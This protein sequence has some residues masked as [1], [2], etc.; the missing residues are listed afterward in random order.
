[1]FAGN[2][3]A[4]DDDQAFADGFDKLAAYGNSQELG[5]QFRWIID[6]NNDG[7]VN[8]GEGD[9]LTIQPVQAGFNV[10][11]AI[12]VAGNFDGNAANGDEIGLYNLGTWVLDFDRDFIIET[13]GNDT[14]VNGNLFGFPIVGD[15]DGDG[16]DDLGVFNNDVFT[17]DLANDGLG[18]PNLGGLDFVAS[19]LPTNDQDQQFNWGFPGVLDRPVTADF[20]QDGIDD[21]GLWVPRDNPQN[22]DA[23]AEW[24]FL[25]SA[26]PTGANRVTGTVNTL[27]HAFEPSPF[28]NDLYAEFGNELASPIVGN[29]DPPVAADPDPDPNTIE[30]DPDFDQDGDVDGRD[31]LAWQ[32]GYNMASPAHSDGDADDSGTVDEYD[33]A[34]WSEEFGSTQ[35]PAAVVNG[36][37]DAGAASEQTAEVAGELAGPQFFITELSLQDPDL[38]GFS[39]SAY[40]DAGSLQES[41]AVDRALTDWDADVGRVESVD[42]VQV[43]IAPDDPLDLAFAGDGRLLD[44][45]ED[46][47]TAGDLF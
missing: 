45:F 14:I 32:L 19:A 22:P 26:D 20:D 41:V 18:D 30:G 8:T 23:A 37:G 46:D 28:G 44:A 42:D 9:I 15:F 16:L 34:I 10:A 36:E 6:T 12:P 35:L 40:D 21:I 25:I 13:N 4:E 7:V 31:F 43:E 27:D 29:F 3:A 33:L 17:F 5:N 39:S 38:T 24:F 47:D 11:G 1:M 2:F